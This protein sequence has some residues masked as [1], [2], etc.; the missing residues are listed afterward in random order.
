[1]NRGLAIHDANA[2]GLDGSTPQQHPRA[3]DLPRWITAVPRLAPFNSI[4]TSA[5][6]GTRAHTLR[7][8][9]HGG[10]QLQRR[11]E[12]DRCLYRLAPSAQQMLTFALR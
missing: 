3:H 6:A 1:M 12:L 8:S 11:G 4:A 2:A 5:A 7:A 10:S 9:L